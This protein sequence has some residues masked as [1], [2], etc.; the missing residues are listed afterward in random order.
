MFRIKPQKQTNRKIKPAQNLKQRAENRNVKPFAIASL[1]CI[2]LLA[3]V[4]I[5]DR[6]SQ[7]IVF[8]ISQVAI[9]GELYN[10]DESL[11]KH[12]VLNDLQQGFFDV[13]LN[14]FVQ[15]I[16]SINWIAQAT[17][18]RIW[19]NKIEVLIREH[20][21]VA[22]WG[23]KTL[24]S[25]KGILFKVASLDQ[26]RHLAIVTGHEIDAKELLLAYSELDRLITGFNL[27]V[28]ALKRVKSGEMNVLFNTNL[29]AT[30]ALKDKQIQFNR[31][32]AL[33]SSGFIHLKNNKNMMHKKPLKSIDMRYSNGFSVVWQEQQIKLNKKT[34]KHTNGKHHA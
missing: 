33:L 29:H 5:Y 17:L 34:A 28:V 11:L 2:L 1:L 18:R 19:P 25:S 21:A 4:L 13:D 10:V 23:D 15:E 7:Q 32:V 6:V 24:I 9:V 8:P 14:A 3:V 26:H 20:Q 30:F 16:E 27:Q 31:F 12:L 22:V